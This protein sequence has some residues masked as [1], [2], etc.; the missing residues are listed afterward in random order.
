MPGRYPS[1]AT[2]VD[3][4][5]GVVFSDAAFR[6]RWRLTLTAAPTDTGTPTGTDTDPPSKPTVSTTWRILPLVP[7][8][9]GSDLTAYREDDADFFSAGSP[10]S[11]THAIANL[12][13]MDPP[14]GSIDIRIFCL[15]NYAD[16]LWPT[17]HIDCYHR[18]VDPDACEDGQPVY[19]APGPLRIEPAAGGDFVTIGDYVR[20]VGRWM[21][22]DVVAGDLARWWP[23]TEKMRGGKA[24]ANG[25][26]F[27]GR[28]DEIW[29]D[30]HSPRAPG[31]VV[32][33]RQ[34]VRGHQKAMQSKGQWVAQSL[35]VA[36]ALRQG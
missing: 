35:A 14:I 16:D 30:V 9:D 23:R 27:P 11:D 17:L 4:G 6:L 5:V 36:E 24:V 10:W 20:A 26:L 7:G 21:E 22:S 31:S 12:P 28:A 29:L 34:W 13:L 19:R 1:F 25:W 18:E 2:L 32:R 8:S 33:N 15:E 3:L